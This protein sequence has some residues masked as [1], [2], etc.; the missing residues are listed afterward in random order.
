MQKLLIVVRNI[1]LT[2]FIS[3]LVAK[4]FLS[5][6][7]PG[8]GLFMVLSGGLLAMLYF[9]LGFRFFWGNSYNEILSKPIAIVAFVLQFAIS[10]AIVGALFQ[11]LCF[12]GANISLTAACV[13]LLISTVMLFLPKFNIVSTKSAKIHAVVSLMFCIYMLYMYSTPR[14]NMLHTFRMVGQEYENIQ[15]QTSSLDKHSYSICARCVSANDV[16]I[17]YEVSVVMPQEEIDYMYDRVLAPDDK[18]DVYFTNMSSIDNVL[19]DSDLYK[20][21]SSERYMLP[22]ENSDTMRLEIDMKTWKFKLEPK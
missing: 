21:I 15:T 11:S 16:S 7:F 17:V 18:L 9:A 1:L 8:A 10:L 22:Y 19:N 14:M 6:L 20:E 13:I 12:P 3:I 4:Q 2:I 5:P